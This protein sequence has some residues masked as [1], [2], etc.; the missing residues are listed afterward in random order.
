MVIIIKKYALSILLLLLVMF[1][2]L[3]LVDVNFNTMNSNK[4][5][6]TFAQLEKMSNQVYIIK[7]LDNNIVVDLENIKE[8]LIT[9][10][11]QYS[12]EIVKYLQ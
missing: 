3:F 11:Y 2:G 1:S 7:I 4:N 6:Q 12:K 10:L 9:T 8:K 5:I